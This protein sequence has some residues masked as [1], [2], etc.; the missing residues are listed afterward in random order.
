MEKIVVGVSMDR[1]LFKARRK[2]RVPLRVVA[3]LQPR[4]LFAHRVWWLLAERRGQEVG[5][6]DDVDELVDDGQADERDCDACQGVRTTA[7]QERVLL[8]P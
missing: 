3:H 1:R 2:K 7:H 8:R 6:H 4:D 5:I